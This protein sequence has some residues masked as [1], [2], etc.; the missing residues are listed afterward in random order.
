MAKKISLIF[1]ISFLA[2]GIWG[3]IT[4]AHNHNLIIFGV[5]GSHNGVHITSGILG[6]AAFFAG[7]KLSRAFL[8]F[9]AIGYG[10]VTLAGFFQAE[11]IIEI[12]NLNM[13]DNFLHLFFTLIAAYGVMKSRHQTA[14]GVS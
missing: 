4:G 12:L 14:V 1:G 13:S 10:I 8:A 7:E 2:V 5:N 6:L 9:V 11:G 3:F